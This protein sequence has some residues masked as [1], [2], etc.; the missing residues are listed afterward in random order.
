MMIESNYKPVH[1][2]VKHET[3]LRSLKD[4]CHPG[5]AHFENDQFPIRKDKEREKR[6]L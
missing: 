2:L 3:V 1:C 5:L 4:D 6:F